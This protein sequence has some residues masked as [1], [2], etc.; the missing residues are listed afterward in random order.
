MGVPLH[1][2]FGLNTGDMLAVV[3]ESG[4]I[5]RTME[6]QKPGNVGQSVDNMG[7]CASTSSLT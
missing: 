4:N 3:I 5:Y 7:E 2:H 6:I 1:S